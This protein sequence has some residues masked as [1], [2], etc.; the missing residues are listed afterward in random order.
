MEKNDDDERHHGDVFLNAL[1]W[2]TDASVSHSNRKFSILL[3]I[4]HNFIS[5][6]KLIYG[7]VKIQKPLQYEWNFLY[8]VKNETAAR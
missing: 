6:S 4:V 8:I 2:K 1:K 3:S 5:V 7:T